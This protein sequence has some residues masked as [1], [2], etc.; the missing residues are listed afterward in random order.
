MPLMP[1]SLNVVCFLCAFA[2]RRALLR[3]IQ[4]VPSLS[5]NEGYT[6]HL[7]YELYSLAWVICHI[8]AHDGLQVNIHGINLSEAWHNVQIELVS[9]I[10]II[11]NSIH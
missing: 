8:L 5:P 7:V 6:N 1:R 2:R 3:R 9:F 11:S 4:R 10:L